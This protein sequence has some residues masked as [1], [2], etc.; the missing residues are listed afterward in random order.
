MSKVQ[1]VILTGGVGSRL[2]PLSRV[3]R[4]KQYLDIF[5][6]KS[7]FELTIERNASF[8]EGLIVVGNQMNRSLSQKAL[9]KM[10]RADY[11]N[12]TE[13]TPRN[14]APAIAFAA[15]AADPED[16]L[17]VTPADHI[18]KEGAE[19]TS[20][21]N[22]GIQWAKE[23]F[24][25]TFGIKPS[26][27]ETGFGYIEAH[28]NEVASFRE[29]PS[30]DLAQEFLSKG[31]FLWN[32]GIFC[33]KAGLYLEE[34]RVHAPEIYR[35][36]KEAFGMANNLEMEEASSMA[37]PSESVDY[38]VMEKSDKIKVVASNFNWSD[39]GSFEALYDYLKEQG[40][41]VDSA[42]NMYIG[43]KAFTEFIGV[44]NCILVQ[45]EDANLVLHKDS[46]QDVKKVYQNLEKN[47]S[48]LIF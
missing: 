14:T 1:H 41:L 29:K 36:S 45:T 30:L 37:I 46:S 8:S 44:E 7:L 17:L 5:S 3:S 35:T 19:Y 24:I 25:V 16:V 13:F 20:A 11:L 43:N 26:R 31:N 42:G 40:H 38:A 9:Q 48:N 10:G 32:S 28:G 2:W 33:F 18:I 15:F 12:I 21:I 6:D 27:P 23:G 39:M 34:L 4:P 47:N 22:E